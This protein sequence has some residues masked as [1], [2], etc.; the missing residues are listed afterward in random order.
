[1]D[2]QEHCNAETQQPDSQAYVYTLPSAPP[3]TMAPSGI[4]RDALQQHLPDDQPCL[5]D[6]RGALR[7][8]LCSVLEE[9]VLR[10][11]TRG[12]LTARDVR[13]VLLTKE[14]VLRQHLLQE[15]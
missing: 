14:R 12:A 11:S 10:A 3:D 15:T 5:G 4:L 8:H 7:R 9:C 1:M 13:H 6:L 2:S